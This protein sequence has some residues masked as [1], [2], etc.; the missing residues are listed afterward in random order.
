MTRTKRALNRSSNVSVTDLA[1]A[2]QSM[3]INNS[4]IQGSSSGSESLSREDSDKIGSLIAVASVQNTPPAL[5]L[6]KELEDV[7]KSGI[8]R[9]IKHVRLLN[10]VKADITK[11]GSDHFFNAMVLGPMPQNLEIVALLKELKVI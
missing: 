4:A 3:A 10:A 11:T 6:V 1:N 5:L 2:T 7:R 8:I 9:D